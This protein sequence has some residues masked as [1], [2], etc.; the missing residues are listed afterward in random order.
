MRRK[1]HP[2]PLRPAPNQRKVLLQHALPLNPWWLRSA[3]L[4]ST[5]EIY[6]VMFKRSRG[7]EVHTST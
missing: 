7:V 1:G 5:Y 4:K 3:G 6:F 2:Q